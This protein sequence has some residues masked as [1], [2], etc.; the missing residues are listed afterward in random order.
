MKNKKL[1]HLTFEDDMLNEHTLQLL[2]DCTPPSLKELTFR[3]VAFFAYGDYQG[4]DWAYQNRDYIS[5]HDEGGDGLGFAGWKNLEVLN[6]EHCKETCE[7]WEDPFPEVLPYLTTNTAELR[8]FCP[9]LQLN[10]ISD[11]EEIEDKEK[12]GEDEEHKDE[13]EDDEEDE[14]EEEEDEDE[15]ITSD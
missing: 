13:D 6:I 3:N 10:V 8:N 4:S 15:V 1:R 2:I 9:N 12:K 7:T 5:L 11:E 14:E